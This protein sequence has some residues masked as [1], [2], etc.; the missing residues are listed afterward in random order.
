MADLFLDKILVKNNRDQDELDT[1]RE[2]WERLEN[3]VILLFFAKSRSS[4]C[5]EFAPL[6]KDFFV[7]LTDEFYVDRSSQL[8]L[9]YVSLDQ[10]E[11][12]Q[13]RFLKD[14][15]KR[16][17]FVPFK[18][19]EFRRNLEAQ[20]SVS[21]V[22]VLVVLKPSGHVISFNAVDE[23]V[24]LGP[25]CFKNWQEV[26]EIIDRSFLLPEFTDDRAGRSMTDPIRRIKYKDETTNEKKKRK[27]CDDEDEGGGGGTEFF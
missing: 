5:Q 23:V 25:P 3:R 16:W 11:E 15:P 10:S 21:R 26:S 14:M 27:H 4:Q 1:E 2:I 8:A 13:E 9:V 24:R 19:E 12:E 6:L 17:L 7:R 18:D 22:P 20:F